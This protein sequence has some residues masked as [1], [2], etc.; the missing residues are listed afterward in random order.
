MAKY[1]L[2]LDNITDIKRLKGSAT[3]VLSQ[4]EGGYNNART[5]SPPGSTVRIAFPRGTNHCL[6]LDDPATRIRLQEAASKHLKWAAK[7]EARANHSESQRAAALAKARACMEALSKE[8]GTVHACGGTSCASAGRMEWLRTQAVA[9][10]KAAKSRMLRDARTASIPPSRLRPGYNP[11]PVSTT[12]HAR[13]RG[14]LRGIGAE[15][16]LAL[17]DA[18]LMGAPGVW[19]QP[20]TDE[21]LLSTTYSLSWKIVGPGGGAIILSGDARWATGKKRAGVGSGRAITVYHT[22]PGRGHGQG[23]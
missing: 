22:R 12:Y 16:R 20:Q 21:H 13:Q 14:A 23:V 17:V 18:A 7:A 10:L 8:D 15:Y 9:V 4:L 3:A 11:R 1:S 19:V 5:C 6:H 2:Y